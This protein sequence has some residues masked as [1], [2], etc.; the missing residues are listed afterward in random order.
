[1]TT[2]VC[3]KNIEYMS[4]K[5]RD[6]WLGYHSVKNCEYITPRPKEKKIYENSL[7]RRQQLERY[8]CECDSAKKNL[9]EEFEYLNFSSDA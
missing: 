2:I 1:M 7:K 6:H 9:S 3:G 8:N 5:Q 4:L